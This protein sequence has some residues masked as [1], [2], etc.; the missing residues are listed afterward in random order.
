MS[1][2]GERQ[3]APL[4]FILCQLLSLLLIFRL[5]KWRL[6]TIITLTMEIISIQLSNIFLI[7]MLEISTSKLY[8]RMLY[9]SYLLFFLS[10]I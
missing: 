10:V 1:G 4:N 2:T 8:L 9:N 6:L 3:G 7:I 5:G